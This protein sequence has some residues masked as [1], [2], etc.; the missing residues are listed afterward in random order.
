[1]DNVLWKSSHLFCKNLL[2]FN[3]CQ[4]MR[5][6]LP[7]LVILVVE[8]RALHLSL[9]WQ[10]MLNIWEI[11]SME[12]SNNFQRKRLLCE[13]KIHIGHIERTKTKK[14]N[15]SRYSRDQHDDKGERQNRIDMGWR[16]YPPLSNNWTNYCRH[17]A[18]L[19]SFSYL[20]KTG[21]R[22]G[23]GSEGFIMARTSHW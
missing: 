20:N 15:R 9:G 10:N 12:F 21:G 3:F 18:Y 4:K 14:R 8:S 23:R 13:L 1:M 17:Q 19:Y 5:P 7:P 16:I 6:S 2:S 11:H 22:G